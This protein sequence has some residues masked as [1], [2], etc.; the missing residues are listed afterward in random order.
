MKLFPVKITIY[1]ILTENHELNFAL[2]K[3]NYF[4][5]LILT[6]KELLTQSPEIILICYSIVHKTQYFSKG[7]SIFVIFLHHAG[8]NVVIEMIV[9]FYTS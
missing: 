6:Y 9:I 4:R 5:I 8:K 3:L 2:M 7:L 1:T